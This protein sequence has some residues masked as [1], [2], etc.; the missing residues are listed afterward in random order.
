MNKLYVVID[1]TGRLYTVPSL[2]RFRPSNMVFAARDMDLHED[3]VHGAIHDAQTILFID[4]ADSS[5]LCLKGS[6]TMEAVN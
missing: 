6:L 4:G 3:I 5:I 2:N 1:K